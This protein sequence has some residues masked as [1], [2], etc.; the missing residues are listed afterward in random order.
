MADEASII[1]KAYE[2]TTNPVVL[3]EFES[4]WESYLDARLEASDDPTALR[5]AAINT[6]ILRAIEIIDRIGAYR[7]LSTRAQDMVDGN[8]G[9]GLLLSRDGGITAHN[10]DAA[11]LAAGCERLSQLDMDGDGAAAI[12]GFLAEGADGERARFIDVHLGG[13]DKPSC[14]LLTWLDLPDDAGKDT[15]HLLVSQVDFRVDPDALPS[16]QARFG[17]TPAETEIAEALMAGD[18]ARDIAE[19]RGVAKT[20]LDKQIKTLRHKV[21]AASITDLVRKLGLMGATYS[22]VTRQV[23]RVQDRED[24][25]A[26]VRMGALFMRDGRRLEFAEQGHPNGVPVLSIHTLMCTGRL[27]RPGAFAAVARGYRYLTPSRRLYGNSEG[28][29]I[30]DTSEMLDITSDDFAELLDHLGIASAF[31]VGGDY[32]VHFAARHPSRVR[33]ILSVNETPLWRDDYLP[34]MSKRRRNMVKTSIHAPA[35][36]R[37]LARVGAMMVK[38]G[39]ARDFIRGSGRS[40]RPLQPALQ[41]PDVYKA[42]EESAYFT[43]NQGVEGLSADVELYHTDLTD[44]V[45]RVR[46]PIAILQGTRC[47]SLP[48]IAVEDYAQVARTDRI[49]RIEGAGQVMRFSHPKAIFDALDGLAAEGFDPL[50]PRLGDAR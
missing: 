18:S 46:A 9:F 28:A 13:E 42:V 17:L 37:Y 38:T 24:A 11:P 26:L 21:D 29:P 14:L 6:H 7:S 2:A 27:T 8:P 30:R 40:T 12:R 31:V 34:Y 5:D 15:P 35:A 20:T 1:G 39:R 22:T 3:D 32:A 23:R 48:D 36:V 19:A 16:L 25:G 50:A 33:G 10:Q 41:D 47:G 43:V 4:Y 49:T 45:E 44:R